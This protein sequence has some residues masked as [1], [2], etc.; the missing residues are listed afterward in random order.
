VKGATAAAVGAIGGAAIILGQGAIVDV[1]TAA[2][3]LGALAVLYFKKLKEALRHRARRGGGLD[4]RR[5]GLIPIAANRVCTRRT[6]VRHLTVLHFGKEP[7]ANGCHAVQRRRGP[8]S[9]GERRPASS[10]DS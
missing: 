8:M 7:A 2:V 10:L 3:F 5:A 9:S 1:V 6:H 4:R